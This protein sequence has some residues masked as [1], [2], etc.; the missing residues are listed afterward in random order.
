MYFQIRVKMDW[1][2]TNVVLGF[3]KAC[4]E[5]LRKIRYYSLVIIGFFR[6]NF[7][8][9]STVLCACN[10]VYMDSLKRSTTKPMSILGSLTDCAPAMYQHVFTQTV[11]IKLCACA[12]VPNNKLIAGWS[13]VY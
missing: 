13:L 8:S 9:V 6:V 11:Q 12:S 3:G 7:V 2:L 4:R 10:R 5:V 1:G